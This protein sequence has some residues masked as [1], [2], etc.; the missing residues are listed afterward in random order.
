MGERAGKTDTQEYSYDEQASGEAPEEP[1]DDGD[2]AEEEEEED[3]SDR[4]MSIPKEV[5]TA[6]QN[7]N[8]K[9]PKD[10]DSERLIN[11]NYTFNIYWRKC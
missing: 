3:N 8:Y 9:V 1:L 6:D 10:F 7:D 5:A 2:E 11:Y 4:N